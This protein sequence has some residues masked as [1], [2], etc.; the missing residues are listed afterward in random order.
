VSRRDGAQA[1]LERNSH[2][3]D[4]FGNT[5]VEDLLEN[6]Q[7][8]AAREQIAAVGRA[9]VSVRDG[10][11]DFLRH[12]G[13]TDR[14]PAAESLAHRHEIRRQAERLKVEWMPCPAQTALHLVGDEEGTRSS[15]R[16][17]DGRRKRRCQRH[18]P[19]FAEHRLRNDCRCRR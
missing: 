18:N 8:R 11:G 5:V 14:H 3:S 15:A 9:V 13:G 19:A 10:I 6:R 2:T 16:L 12:E 4:V 17:A 1:L 7:C